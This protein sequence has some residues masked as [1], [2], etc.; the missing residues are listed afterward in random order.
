MLS[1]QLVFLKALES[2]GFCLLEKNRI[3]VVQ[4]LGRSRQ[5]WAQVVR[6]SRRIN[7]GFVKQ[8]R[9]GA[10]HASAEVTVC[11]RDEPRFSDG[12]EKHLEQNVTWLHCLG[13]VDL[14]Y[15]TITHNVTLR[16]H[17]PD[18]IQRSSR[19]SC[20]MC[21]IRLDFFPPMVLFPQQQ[22]SCVGEACCCS[23]VECSEEHNVVLNHIAP[24]G[25]K[26]VCTHTHTSN[27][28]KARLH[29]LCATAECIYRRH[30]TPVSLPV[31]LL[32]I[33]SD[34]QGLYSRVEC[35]L[36]KP[37]QTVLLLWSR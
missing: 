37:Q 24:T 2:L 35:L 1:V 23:E 30:V 11:T 21:P 4:W 27:K 33:M 10:L 15:V 13:Y 34:G 6:C 7:K 16:T 12:I 9:L 29:W 36:F 22:V 31:L 28:G 26:E 3:I 5:F 19:R 20:P 25:Y 18:P 14:L 32:Q 8:R 17:T